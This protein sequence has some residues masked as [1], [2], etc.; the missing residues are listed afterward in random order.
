[1][2]QSPEFAQG[3]DNKMVVGLP[4]LPTISQF[5]YSNNL[6]FL[7][8]KNPANIAQIYVALTSPLS[9]NQL[10]IGVFYSPPPYQHM[11]FLGVLAN[12]NP[13]QIITTNWGFKQE[14]AGASDVKL[15]LRV[16]NLEAFRDM[17]QN[18]L[19]KNSQS[20]IYIPNISLV[21]ITILYSL[22]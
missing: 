15:V 9:S 17:Y 11:I 12:E 22:L 20:F 21:I 4:G 6:T 10:G 16:D 5:Q 19:S 14:L 8:V 3:L 18:S 1:M 2:L 7:D 13:G